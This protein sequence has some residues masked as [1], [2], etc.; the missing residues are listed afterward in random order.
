MA[1]YPGVPGC[2]RSSGRRH[3]AVA[4]PSVAMV[5]FSS[6]DENS[7]STSE[8]IGGHARRQRGQL[9]R[10]VGQRLPKSMVVDSLDMS[11]TAEMV[12]TSPRW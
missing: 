12:A 11:C 6:S 2:R 7:L 5:A 3:E 10:E 1:R 8:R 9:Q 4:S